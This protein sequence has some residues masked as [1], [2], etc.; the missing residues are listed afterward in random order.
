MCT[1]H[2][3]GGVKRRKD[4]VGTGRNPKKQLHDESRCVGVKSVQTEFI[5]IYQTC[6]LLL[7]T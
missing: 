7:K 3:S 4:A 2:K 1:A 6:F 5:N